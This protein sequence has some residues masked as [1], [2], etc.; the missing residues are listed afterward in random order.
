MGHA[1]HDNDPAL[2]AY[3]P[4]GQLTQ[5]VWNALEAKVPS[6]QGPHGAS[7]VADAY[8]GAQMV[9]EV[10]LTALLTSE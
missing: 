9:H 3:L 4:T 10:T 5:L 8:P 6:E 1:I 2:A 7:P